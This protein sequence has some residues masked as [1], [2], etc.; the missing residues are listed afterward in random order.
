MRLECQA[1]KCTYEDLEDTITA[2]RIVVGIYNE[3][4][5]DKLL[6]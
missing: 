3:T 1:Q 6:Q 2:D 5:H 4:V